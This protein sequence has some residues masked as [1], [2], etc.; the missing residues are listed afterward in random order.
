MAKSETWLTILQIVNEVQR[1]LGV[2]PTATLT[3]TKQATTLLDRITELSLL[4][5]A[6]ETELKQ[7]GIPE[8][9]IDRSL[10]LFAK[11]YPGAFSH[12]VEGIEGLLGMPHG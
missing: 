5:E 9:A 6:L 4:Y 2:T 7:R 10:S 8:R 12:V 3:A 11:V 1:R